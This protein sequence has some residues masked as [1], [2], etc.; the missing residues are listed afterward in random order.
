MARWNRVDL[1]SQDRGQRT[2]DPN[3]GRL[4]RRALLGCASTALASAAPRKRP[5]L[6]YVFPDQWR[7][8]A[9]GFMQ[10]DPVQ[11]PVLDAFAKQS[12]VLTHAISN[13]P[14]CSPY[15]AMLMTGRY[16]LSNGV[17][18]N[19]TNANGVPASDLRQTD[20]CFPDVLNRAGYSLGYIGKWH[21]DTPHQPFIDTSNN[22]GNVKWNEW[23][24][25]E[26]RHGFDYWHAY[27]TYDQ[28]NAPQYWENDA[29]RERRVTASKWGPEYETDLA[30][31]YL[32]NEGGKFRRPDEPFALF[33]AHNPPHTDYRQVPD[34]YVQ[35]YAGKSW[36]DLINRPN[37]DAAADTKLI[38]ACKEDIRY[39]FAQITGVD[40][41][42]GRL[43]RTLDETGL[44]EDTI[45]VFTSDHGNCVGCHNE[46]T[47]NNPYDES[48]RVPF[49]VR[50]PGAIRPRRDDLLLSTPDIMPTLLGLAGLEGATPREVEGTNYAALFRGGQQKRP[51]SALYFQAE[52]NERGVRTHRYTLAF[53]NQGGAPRTLLFD[54]TADPYQMHN[55][56]DSRPELVRQLA[57]GELEAWLRRTRDPWKST[58]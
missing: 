51:T 54:N 48:L 52:R 56:A 57:T 11:T 3:C 21:L 8:Q 20:P 16:P 34:R 43:L 55:L 18:R 32:R 1:S 41:Q 9:L 31:R 37:F 49:L 12:L 46:I 24:P 40:E 4:S 27:G 2:T 29:P 10:Q 50:W 53:S 15:R 17:T 47:K 30:I 33:V 58:I 13:A 22:R 39:Y 42:F 23:T 38:R 25:P 6:L 45:V 7:A 5:N 36:S 26:R 14:V 35:R 19:C 28:H 44:A